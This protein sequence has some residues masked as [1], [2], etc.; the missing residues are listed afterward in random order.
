MDFVHKPRP[1]SHRVHHEKLP[2]EIHD[3]H[4]KKVNASAPIP[5]PS[6]LST[7]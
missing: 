5:I 7:K 6:P 4:L 2:S 1:H 3:T